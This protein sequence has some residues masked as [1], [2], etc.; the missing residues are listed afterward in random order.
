MMH[1]S[2]GG[3]HVIGTGER[4]ES[5]SLCLQ[6]HS[7]GVVGS[8]AVVD[9]TICSN[10]PSVKWLPSRDLRYIVVYMLMWFYLDMVCMNRITRIFTV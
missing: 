9:A 7:I 6:D 4:R 10:K 5:G 2:S 1:Q 8:R 3:W